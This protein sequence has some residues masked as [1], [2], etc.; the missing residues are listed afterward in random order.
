MQRTPIHRSLGE[1]AGELTSELLD[2]AVEGELSEGQ[3]LEWKAVFYQG[4]LSVSDFPKD[5]AGMA[6]AGGGLIVF[7]VKESRGAGQAGVASGRSDVELTDSLQREMRAVAYSSLNP[8]LI[9][10][11]IEQIGDVEHRGIALR[12]PAS[13]DAP[14][15]IVKEDRFC[16]PVR[17]GSA[18]VW[19]SERDLERAYRVR[20]EARRTGRRTLVDL[21]DEVGENCDLTK[22]A[23]LVAVAR[24]ARAIQSAPRLSHLDAMKWA[25][26]AKSCLRLSQHLRMIGG[27]ADLDSILGYATPRAG[28]RSQI[29]RNGNS[30]GAGVR[31]SVHDD[32]TVTYATRLG[33][34]CIAKPD[35]GDDIWTEPEDIFTSQLESAAATLGALVSAQA[36]ERGWPETGVDLRVGVECGTPLPLVA[37]TTTPVH[38]PGVR[39]GH[40]RELKRFRPVEASWLLDDTNTVADD[41]VEDLALDLVNQAGARGLSFLLD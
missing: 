26:T 6:N 8:P 3:D 41:Q 4:K 22:A 21:Y 31:I 14:H 17:N 12:V 40:Q 29:F 10:L 35:D 36:A 25:E 33:N 5:I 30:N 23:W 34:R 37:Y 1:T 18:T 19:M 9:G 20:F 11:E 38:K 2:R 13:D 32:G 24:P 15:L 16:V 27:D 39:D 7:G 28:L